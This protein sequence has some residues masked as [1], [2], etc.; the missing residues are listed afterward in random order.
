M[1][2]WFSPFLSINKQILGKFFCKINECSA[3][4]TSDPLFVPAPCECP[5]FTHFILQRERK[6]L[7]FDL[8]QLHTS[9]FRRH[10]KYPR[11]WSRGK[12]ASENQKGCLL[13]FLQSSA[14]ACPCSHHQ[15]GQACQNILHL[16][17]SPEAQLPQERN[18]EIVIAPSV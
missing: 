3:W 15:S 16:P 18:Q 9:T 14:A 2:T 5:L 13:L 1:E 17:L 6:K 7:N 8:W 4:Q 11:N 12:K 10:C